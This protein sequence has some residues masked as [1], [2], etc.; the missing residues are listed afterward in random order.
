[1]VN[2]KY[3]G[4]ERGTV[5][6]QSRWRAFR[7]GCGKKKDMS[8]KS[9]LYNK[10]V[11]G[12]IWTAVLLGLSFASSRNYL[13][14]HTV[15][16]LFS[17]IVACGIFMLAWNSRR[18]ID[19]SY[20]LFIGIAYLFVAGLDLL[21][22]LSYSGSGILD[23]GGADVS[24]QLWVAARYVQ[25]ISL[26]IAP[27]LL[28][29]K[30]RTTYVMIGYAITVALIVE[31]IFSWNV[32]PA[33]YI[34]GTGLTAF[35]KMSEYAV[36]LIFVVSAGLLIRRRKEFDGGV[37]RLLVWSFVMTIAS[38]L[39]FTF[40]AGVYD[41]SNMAGHLFKVTAFYL[42]YKAIIQTGLVRPY[43]LLCRNLKQ[44]EELL[45]E[46]KDKIQKYLDI[47]GVMF[48]VLDKD[49]KVSLI[50]KKGC[51]ILRCDEAEVMGK[52]WFDA[53]SPEG[54]RSEVKRV[55]E[56]LVAGDVV[57][58]EYFESPILT[59]GGGE[60]VIAWHNTVLK[61]EQGA[62]QAVLSSGEDITARKRAEEKLEQAMG[63]LKRSN[64]ELEQFAYIASHD[65]QQPLL[66]VDGFLKLIQRR[67]VDKLGPDGNEFIESA[68]DG[69]RQMQSLIRDLLEY[70]RVGRDKPFEPSDCSACLQ[71][72]LANLKVAIEESGAIITNDALPVVVADPTQV[73]QLF[74]N[75]ISNAVK[76]RSEDPPRVHIS[77]KRNGR[78][79][80]FCV[81]DNG[82][83]IA[84]ENTGRIFD[85]FQRLHNKNE[86]PGTGIGLAICKKIAE[87]HGGRI[88][89]ESG[90]GKGSTFY[91]TI[92]D[93]E[94]SD[95]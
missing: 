85:I 82:M 66:I 25:G 9:V 26:L 93:R 43:N 36:S 11:T 50:N 4:P 38:E 94:D 21:H 58:V 47:A 89:A 1:M 34:G 55:Y 40:Y 83:G 3:A 64:A 76:Y 49:Q 24:T 57:P 42:M 84:P 75:L 44:S 77:A 60:R 46:E 56:K 19:N 39:F 48:V 74:Q 13:L 71:R 31:A 45:R 78:E 67:Y 10:F 81:R 32:F 73:T 91:F 72:S 41:F 28:G 51:E 15:A 54:I 65:L 16:E 29:R 17:I 33:C 7:A 59:A 20:F 18:F 30:V 5:P 2:L 23:E 27:F 90:P 37:L 88:W 92:P 52:M 53:F 12:L 80:T 62:V 8:G 63:E 69:A 35:K 14:F 61:D 86:Y 22:A 68:L 79:W 95:L 87:R 6:V 70:A